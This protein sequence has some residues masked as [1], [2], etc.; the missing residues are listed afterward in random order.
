MKNRIFF[1][2]FFT[3]L[4]AFTGVSAETDRAS[5]LAQAEPVT[6]A[7]L[8]I[9]DPGLLPT[10]PF[11]FFK[12]LGR[13]F[14]RVITRNPIARAELE[15]KIVN[16]K[17]A[18]L[19]RVEELDGNNAVAIE[20]AIRNYRDN[21]EKLKDR[22]SDLERLQQNPDMERLLSD[23]A[24][25]AVKHEKLFDSLAQKFIN[26]EEIGNLSGSA[27]GLLEQSVATAASK[28][29]P[30]K[31]AG[32]IRKALEEAKGGELKNSHSAEIIGRLKESAGEDVRK[33]LDGIQKDFS[34]QARKDIEKLLEVRSVPELENVL[35]ELPM[36]ARKSEI[37]EKIFQKQKEELNA[38]PLPPAVISLP[39]EASLRAE[40]AVC[41]QIRKNLDE[42]WDL[43]KASR[44][45]EQEYTQ[46]Y[47]VLKKQLATCEAASQ[48]VPAKS[49]VS[50]EADG[51][52]VCTQQ[53]DPV[54]GE[55]KKTYSNACVAKAS[56]IP[57][58]YRGE[59]GRPEEEPL[60]KTAP[61]ATS[62]ASV[63][64]P[65]LQEFKLEADDLG[66]YPS[67]AIT[68]PKNSKVKIH[69][70][71]RTN[72]VYYGGLD[73]R[74]PKFKTE[75]VKPGGEISV[76]FIAD[77]SFEF[78]SYWPLSGVIKSIGKVTVQ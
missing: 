46:K 57:V 26:N 69:F 42:V 47:E 11:Y 5:L 2:L 12:E 24:D 61:A 64:E 32:K 77:E 23:F 4:L 56:G 50:V 51:A 52:I 71:V 31:F 58:Q 34:E 68:V 73:F 18:E 54:C 33:A 7:D 55:N 66:F 17:A 10:N 21:Q 1:I 27:Q 76:E 15:L 8:G 41:D 59:C 35:N 49:D 39:P 65:V 48:A 22:F 78:T 70:I 19:K 75:S 67:N 29:D 38:G 45:N 3:G 53:Y 25:K 13:S 43:Y 60:L 74:S 63:S 37:G 72:N 36:S 16:E 9:E 14:R 40:I 20:K 28:D 6:I 44:L 62:D 30:E